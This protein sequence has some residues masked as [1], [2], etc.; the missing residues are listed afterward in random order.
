M[1]GAMGLQTLLC[2]YLVSLLTLQAMPVLGLATGRSKSSEVCGKAFR[3]EPG[4]STWRG[5][6]RDTRPLFR[7]R[8]P[9]LPPSTSPDQTGHPLQ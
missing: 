9:L 4:R 1:D 3:A 5:P 7:D 8:G 2:V 6:W